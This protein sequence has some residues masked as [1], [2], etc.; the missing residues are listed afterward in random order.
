MMLQE[1]IIK[2]QLRHVWLDNYSNLGNDRMQQLYNAVKSVN[3]DC[4]VMATQNRGGFAGGFP[5]DIAIVEEYT[6]YLIRTT[7]LINKREH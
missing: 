5:C 7:Q 4:L 2:F 3:T 6:Y 1:L